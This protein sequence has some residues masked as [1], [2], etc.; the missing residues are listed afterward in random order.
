MANIFLDLGTHFGQGLREF[1]QKYSMDSNWEIYTFEAN[2]ITY[3]K[4]KDE[5]LH[6]TPN[7]ISYNRAVSNVDDMIAINLETPPNEDATGMGS[8]TISLDVW[9]PWGSDS[10]KDKFKQTANVLA[11]DLSSYILELFHREDFIVIKMDIEGSEYDVLEKM[12]QDNSIYLIDEIYIEWHAKY[13][14]NKEDILQ[15]ENAIIEE[16]KNRNIKFYEWR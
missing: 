4:F 10:S 15:R 6:L 3:K 16:L 1:I 12:I 14:K 7:V 13:F 9:D 2:P 11:F 5:F 8:S